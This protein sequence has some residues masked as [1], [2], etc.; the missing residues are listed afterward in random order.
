MKLKYKLSKIIDVIKAM[1]RRKIIAMNPYI[2]KNK[3][4]QSLIL[5]P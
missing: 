3:D 2:N 4:L 5:H 1:L